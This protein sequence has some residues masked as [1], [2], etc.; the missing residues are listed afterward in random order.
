MLRRL[1]LPTL[2]AF[3]LALGFFIYGSTG[4]D[5]SHINFWNVHTLL[6]QGEL[7]NYNGER[8]EQ[9]TSLL[10]DFMTAA[11]VFITNSS[12]VTT[13]Y[14]VDIAAAFGCAVLATTI[15]R[16]YA[17]ALAAYT[18]TLL[19]SSASFLLW[20]FGGMGEPLTALCLLF[21]IFCWWRWLIYGK[22]F[23]QV[24]CA[25]LA[26]VLVRPEIPVVIAAITAALVIACYRQQELRTRAWILFAVTLCATCTLFAW[27]QWYFGSWL[28]LPAIAKQGG[29]LSAQLQR[30]SYYMIFGIALNPIT[31]LALLFSA[32]MLLIAAKSW[33]KKTQQPLDLLQAILLC[34]FFV[35]VGFIWTAGGDWMQASRFFV[36]IIPIA[37]LLLLHIL[38]KIPY[39]AVTHAII[40]LLIAGQLFLQLPVIT[41]QSHGIPVWV[42]TYIQQEHTAR[43]GVFE[44][45]N[46]EHVRDMA[47][48][49]HLAE[50]IPP[51]H[52]QLNRPLILMSGQAG[53]VFYYTAQQFYGQ[54]IFRDLR[55]LVESSLTLCQELRALPR[56]PQGLF[57]GYR[58]FFEQQPSLQ[59]T[60]GISKPDIIYDINDMTQKLSK[61][62]APYGYTLVH[63][64]GGFPVAN[65]T[66]LPYNRLLAPNLIFVRNNLL[67]LLNNPSLRVYYYKDLP[68]IYRWPLN[69]VW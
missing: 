35:Y 26:L 32:P 19:F 60:C 10:Q 37:T 4:H 56:S 17:P 48:I 38:Q 51:L 14:L 40:S 22:H 12:I 1:A 11:L 20:S 44:K 16:Q 27:Q 66:T 65:A 33:W 29:A 23:W 45:L 18:G 34:S 30:G 62:L 58:D 69:H 3:W 50:I 57:W 31:G 59:K 52:Q 47:V 7:V 36:P 42:Q 6:T 13:G 67:P 46:Q 63:R 55:G 5:D 8:I 49:D 64:E 68:L 21:G 25:T 2:Y 54:V 53:M 24:L 39:L 9:T 28:P 15:A 61:T 43:Y 41:R